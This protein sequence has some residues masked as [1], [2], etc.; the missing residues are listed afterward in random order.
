[1]KKIVLSIALMACSTGAL[2]AQYIQKVESFESLNL[3]PNAVI[4]HDPN[5]TSGFTFESLTLSNT[6]TSSWDTYVGF[7]FSNKHDSLTKGYANQFGSIM[8]KG[9]NS[10]TFAVMYEQGVIFGKPN[11]FR[12]DSLRIANSTY[13]YYSML[14]GDQFSKKFGGQSGNDPDFFKVNMIVTSGDGVLVDTL[15]HFLADYRFTDNSKDYI[16]KDWALIDFSG[17]SFPVYQVAFTL[18]STDTSQWGYNTPLYLNLDA[19]YYTESTL[20]VDQPMSTLEVYP[21]PSSSLVYLSGAVDYLDVVDVAGNVLISEHA[22]NQP[23]DLT[24]L[25]AGIYTL[26]LTRGDQK[27]IKRIE[28]I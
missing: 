5:N 22:A 23:I 9:Y 27:S 3:Q 10:S 15:E 14:E 17:V 16:S 24:N 20:G 28:K 26:V 18:E 1:M 25:A 8:G 21:N 11:G 4:N 13:T 6:Y 12:I 7:A 19:I 2:K